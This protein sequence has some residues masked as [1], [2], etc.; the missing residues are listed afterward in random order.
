MDRKSYL[1]V[2]DVKDLC[3]TEITADD[4]ETFVPLVAFECRGL[5]V[6]SW[7]I[8]AARHFEPM[9]VRWTT[10]TGNMIGGLGIPGF[11]IS[12]IV[13]NGRLRKS[14]PVPSAP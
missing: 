14:R 4:S 7:T 8:R 10:E 3:K 11:N 13:D 6:R 1:K 12:T 2:V 5:E 9:Q